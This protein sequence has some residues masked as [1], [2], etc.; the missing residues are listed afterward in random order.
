MIVAVPADTPVTWPV[1]RPGVSA[2]ATAV[3][4]LLHVPPVAVSLSVVVPPMQT[5]F[6]PI[7]AVG[8][9]LMVTATVPVLVHGPLAA[10]AV[11]VIVDAEVAFT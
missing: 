6:V 4:L 11:Y 5:L 2:V 7:M 3:L 9:G 10:V 1:V 8:D